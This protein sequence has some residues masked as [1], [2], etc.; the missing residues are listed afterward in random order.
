MPLNFKAKTFRFK[1]FSGE[2]NGQ[3]YFDPNALS[4]LKY[5]HFKTVR[6]YPLVVLIFT[7]F[8]TY[9]FKSFDLR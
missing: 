9:G 6:L 7:K 8:V 4:I 3:T 1:K 2:F 5:H